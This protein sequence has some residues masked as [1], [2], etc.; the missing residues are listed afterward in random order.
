[1]LKLTPFFE[2]LSKVSLRLRYRANKAPGCLLRIANDLPQRMR[3]SSYAFCFASNLSLDTFVWIKSPRF[4]RFLYIP[5]LPLTGAHPDR[6]P[7]HLT[8]D[9]DSSRADHPF[10]L[11]RTVLPG[12]RTVR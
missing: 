11:P 6:T 3:T 10:Q 8:V 2:W 4:L 5:R 7:S 1:M 9:G 12:A